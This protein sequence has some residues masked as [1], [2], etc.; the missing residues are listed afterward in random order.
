MLNG[1]SKVSLHA[2]S[3]GNEHSFIV[4]TK[5]VSGEMSAEVT[6]EASAIGEPC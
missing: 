1:R 4:Y 3:D 5:F 2:Q 6:V